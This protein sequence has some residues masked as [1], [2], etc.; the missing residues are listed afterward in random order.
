M[1]TS[2]LK[3]ITPRNVRHTRRGGILV[4]AMIFSVAIAMVVAVLIQLTR[5]TVQLSHRS[6]LS[7]AAMNIAEAGLEEAIYTVNQQI[8][9]ADYDTLW[10]SWDDGNS[11]SKRRTMDF[12]SL[13][14]GATAV[15]KVW[16]SDPR[17][18][19]RITVIARSVVTPKSGPKIERWVQVV[20]GR[21]TRFANGIVARDRV[22]FSGGNASVDSYNSTLGDYDATLG[23]GVRN[24]YD[25]GSAGSASVVVDS[26]SISN[27]NIWGNAVIGTPDMSGLDVGPR[28]SV[29]PWGTSAGTIVPGNVLT[30]FTASFD[31]VAYP[32]RNAA[33]YDIST[34]TTNTTLPR[35][36]DSPASDGKYYY[37]VGQISL[38]GSTKILKIDGPVVIRMTTSLGAGAIAVTG[39][40]SGIEVTTRSTAALEVYTNGNIMIAGNGIVNPGAPRKVQI[41]GTNPSTSTTTQTINVRGNGKLSAVLYAPNAD[42]TIS[43]GGSSGWVG[44]AAIAKNVTINGGGNFSYDESLSTL[45]SGATMGLQLWTELTTAAERAVSR[46]NLN[47]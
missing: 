25:R 40:T 41:W 16:L 37:N 21:R 35:T 11:N 12:G 47:F 7:N 5:Q 45:D 38:S 6:F 36:G 22:T 30:D 33:S 15:T 1:N 3:R 18:T 14:R 27:S 8:A 23:T 20:L 2:P 43:G 28:G 34:I 24:K 17:N 32:A 31:E 13:G 10:D 44:G 29:G 4:T 19:A 39:S 26:V 46:A 9:G 42:L